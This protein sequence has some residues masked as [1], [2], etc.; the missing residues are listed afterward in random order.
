MADELNTQEAGGDTHLNEIH[1]AFEKDNENG[2]RIG[3][4]W[5]LSQQGLDATKIAEELKV[6]TSGFVFSYRSY[7]INLTGALPW[8][9]KR[10]ASKTLRR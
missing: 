10:F 2:K 8:S 6:P 4:V 9:S 3:Q 5:K 7:I 1:K